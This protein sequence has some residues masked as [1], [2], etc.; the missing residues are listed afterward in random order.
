VGDMELYFNQLI[1]LLKSEMDQVIKIGKILP[2]QSKLHRL[3]LGEEKVEIYYKFY[4]LISEEEK[5]QIEN[6]L[7]LMGIKKYSFQG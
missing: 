7:V 3:V 4:P 5:E 2:K 1:A 6:D